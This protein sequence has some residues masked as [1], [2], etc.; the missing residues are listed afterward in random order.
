M[1]DLVLGIDVGTG[2]AKAVIADVSGTVLWQAAASYQH[3]SPESEWV[4]QD[5][6]DWWQAVSIA[7]K[8]LFRSHPDAAG[9]IAAVGVS[10]QGAGAVLLNKAGV[11]VRHAILWLDRRCAADA[12]ELQIQH[13]EMFSQISGK[14]P[15]SYN[16]DLKLRWLKQHEPDAWEQAFKACTTTGFITYRLTAQAVTNHS[17]GGIFLAYDLT[18]RCWSKELLGLLDLPE[19]M[20]CDL[21]E[22]DEIIGHVTT[23]AA[24]YTGIPVGIPMVAGGEDTSSA[25]LAMGVTT[26][27]TAQ[28]S[29]GTANTVYVPI[30]R[31]FTHPR[32]LTFPHVLRGKSLIGGSIASGGLA[33]DW[34][35][36]IFSASRDTPTAQEMEE[37]TAIAAEVSV[38]ADGLIFLPYLVGELQPINDGF[39]R[40][41]FFGLNAEMHRGHMMRSIFESNA[42][43]IE[44]NL[45]LARNLGTAPS[46]LVAVGGPMRNVL[47]C[48][49]IA[50]VTGM[51]LHVME[52]HGGA[53]LGSAM[54]AA[55]GAGLISRYN[56]M[57]MA[58]ACLRHHYEPDMVRHQLY[59]D[60]FST[61]LEL[62][63]RL[64]DLFPRAAAL[65]VKT[66]G[67]RNVHI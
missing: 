3:H 14:V 25:G 29:S 41:V 43:A 48:Q 49:I 12:E 23:E 52:E 47:L 28:L 42:F 17:D 11:A 8:T 40:G 10:G 7:T 63:P 57:Q 33:I 54:L 61:Y 51:S 24:E 31:P 45:S 27:D 15:A 20:Y 21:A 32:L 18:N 36:R 38:G 67:V 9:R 2:T 5:P 26:E 44:H 55:K 58:H 65:Q 50:D 6:E 30:D 60:I 37:L 19:S 4:E 39:A 13:G 56:E 66:G 62:Y 59:Q 16:F 46:R 22:C 64:K 53:A 35:A 34:M 1:K